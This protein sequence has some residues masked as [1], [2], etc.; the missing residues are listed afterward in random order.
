VRFINLARE[1]L[2]G[3]LDLQHFVQQLGMRLTGWQATVA[4][5]LVWLYQSIDRN[6][7]VRKMHVMK[8]R[9][10]APIPGLHTFRITDR[11]LHVFPRLIF[12]PPEAP[13]VG[14]AK[15]TKPRAPR[16]SVGV[17]GLDEMLGGG[18]PSGYSVLVAGP[19]GSG[20]TV[21]AT[22]FIREGARRGEPGVIAVEERVGDY[23]GLLTGS[24][25]VASPGS[26]TRPQRSRTR[27][28]RST[29]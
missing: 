8:M 28:P 15:G 13:S 4:D 29:R 18:I 5:G 27:R 22:Q 6:S 17:S 25:H 14:G 12:P 11:G 16:L 7:M 23:Q 2:D 10:Q 26:Q 24:P 9:G 19:S 20:K 21:L 3:G 1:A